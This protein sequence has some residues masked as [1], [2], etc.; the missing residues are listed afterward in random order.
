MVAA[1]IFVLGR[2]NAHASWERDA[3]AWDVVRNAHVAAVYRLQQQPIMLLASAHRFSYDAEQNAPSSITSGELRLKP[4]H[5]PDRTTVVE[6][7]WFDAPPLAPGESPGAYDAQRQLTVLDELF[8]FLLGAL[9]ESIMALPQTL[10]LSLQLHVSAPAQQEHVVQRFQMAWQQ[11][12]LRAVQIAN[13]PQPP[14]LMSLDT[15]LDAPPGSTRDHVTLLIAIQLHN[16][17]SEPPAKASAEAG[18]ALLMLPQDLAQRNR[19]K[20]IA[21]IHRPAAGTVAEMAHTLASALQWGAADAATVHHLWHCGFDKASQ[22]ALLGA[23]RSAGMDFTSNR[24]IEGEHDLDKSIGNAGALS[25]WLA[26]ACACNHAI[27]FGGPQLVAGH[28]G[29]DALFNVVR[30][31]P[32]PSSYMSL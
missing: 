23:V 6:A 22:P 10:P 18:V 12:G 30:A 26:L 2:F 17:V 21:Q 27:S 24:D 11:V 14:S 20:P 28:R 5:T 4:S 19:L 9:R 25:D 29:R 3:H 32:R 16:L 13:D 7:R 31:M 8:A 1:A 15:W